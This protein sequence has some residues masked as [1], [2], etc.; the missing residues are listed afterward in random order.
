V[1]ALDAPF[2]M[3]VV[4][5]EVPTG[6]I[7]DRFGRKVSLSLGSIAF[8]VAIFTFGI[9]D[10]FPLLL[11]AYL[12]WGVSLTL[13]SGADAAFMYD[14][15]RVMGRE[16][17]YQR[18]YGRAFAFQQLGVIAGTVIGAPLAAW[19]DLSVPVV[20]SAAIAV[21][22]WAVTLTFREPPRHHEGEQQ[23]GYVQGI[24][25]AFRAIAHTPALRYLMLLA[26]SVWAAAM[27]FEILRQPFL[28]SHGVEVDLFGW[29]AL[30]GEFVSIL[31]ALGAYRISRMV[32]ANRLVLALP[33]VTGGVGAI[34]GAW[35]SLGAFVFYPLLGVVFG[36]SNTVVSD[37]INARIPSAQRATV[38]SFFSLMFSVIVAPIEPALGAI[39][40]A[41][42]LQ[43]A[44]QVGRSSCLRSRCR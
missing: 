2:W 28:S 19:T 20:I 43:A 21:L 25:I 38:L 44:F 31:M 27:C 42:G 8:A 7:A 17:D 12:A 29:L 35:D 22:A 41:S 3:V 23:A 1:T 6:A 30:P 26:A 34:L 5:M 11:A 18:L 24:K 9:A 36:L 14:T 10:T 15:L 39:A 37:Y 4:L 32:G 13:E 16:S 40:D 33:L